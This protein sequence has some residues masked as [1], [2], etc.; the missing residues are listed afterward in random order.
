MSV[1]YGLKQEHHSKLK[2]EKDGLSL[3]RSTSSTLTARGIADSVGSVWV[4]W[5]LSK[6]GPSDLDIYEELVDIE[7][8]FNV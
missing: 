3:S 4:K 8:I 6:L 5:Q 7:F 1:A 2:S